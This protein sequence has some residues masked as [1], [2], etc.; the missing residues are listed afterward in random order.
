MALFRKL[1]F[2]HKKNR[3]HRRKNSNIK[4]WM[5]MTREERD[6]IDNQKN[7]GSIERKKTSKL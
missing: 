3:K 7:K 1:S 2:L 4:T 5:E 6:A